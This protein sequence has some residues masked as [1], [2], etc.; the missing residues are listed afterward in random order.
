MR[1]LQCCISR[2]LL[3]SLL[4]TDL[5][6]KWYRNFNDLIVRITM[7]IKVFK[8]GIQDRNAFKSFMNVG[9]TGGYQ[10]HLFWTILW[11]TVFVNLNKF[12]KFVEATMCVCIWFT[13]CH[14]F[15]TVLFIDVLIIYS[16]LSSRCFSLPLSDKFRTLL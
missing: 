2:F 11:C 4:R 10:I 9:K 12:W 5:K 14:W 3:I 1:I 13:R 8:N 16:L 7:H 6:G 15:F